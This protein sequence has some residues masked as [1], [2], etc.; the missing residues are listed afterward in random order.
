MYFGILPVAT[1]D[2]K[3]IDELIAYQFTVLDALGI[4]NGPGHAELKYCNHEPVL[5]EVGARCHGGEGT[6]LPMANQCN[7][8]NQVDMFIDAYMDPEKFSSYTDKPTKLLKYGCEAK[9][10]CYQN[11]IL[12]G[13]PGLEEIQSLKSFVRSEFFVRLDGPLTKTV[14]NV[15]APGSVVLI[16]EDERVLQQDLS[17]IRELEH[18]GLFDIE[19]EKVQKVGEDI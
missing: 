2:S 7:G 6:W 18:R 4:R 1:H 15:T 16:H 11:G 14:D 5:I 8:Q 10:V 13:I 9:L 12:R 19:E 3:L 17:R